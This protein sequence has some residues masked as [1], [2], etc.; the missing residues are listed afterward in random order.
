M[1]ETL[2][3]KNRAEKVI[4]KD[5][6]FKYI[7]KRRVD[8]YSSLLGRKKFQLQEKRKYLLS[9]KNDDYENN[10]ENWISY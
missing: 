6:K 4:E 9:L 10:Y 2:R 3:I 1:K 7:P 5:K 8:S